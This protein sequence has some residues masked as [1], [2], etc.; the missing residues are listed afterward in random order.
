MLC[1]HFLYAGY[2][3]KADIVGIEVS[4][5]HNYLSAVSGNLVVLLSVLSKDGA[6][7]VDECVAVALLKDV[8]FCMQHIVAD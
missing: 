2:E 3:G 1:S 5:C 7:V 8:K 6:E 4:Y